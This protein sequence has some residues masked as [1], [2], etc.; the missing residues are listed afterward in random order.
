MLISALCKYYDTL[1]GNGLLDKSGFSRVSVRYRIMLT[2]DGKL[3][4]IELCFRTVPD[5]DKKGNPITKEVPEEYIMPK[6]S[7]KPGID[8]NI[9]EHRPLYI[10]GLAVEKGQLIE[11]D[12]SKKS[13]NAFVAKTLEYTEG[14]SSELVRAYRAFAENWVPSENTDNP[15]LTSLIKDFDKSGYCFWHYRSS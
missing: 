13:H 3:A 9:P 4:D 10:F 15:I 14:M 7:E 8:C 6:R 1:A 11:S 12:K 2:P 5:K